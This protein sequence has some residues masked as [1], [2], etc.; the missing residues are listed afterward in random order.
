MMSNR[1]T[2]VFPGPQPDIMIVDH[3]RCRYTSDGP[4]TTA[5]VLAVLTKLEEMGIRWC[6][7]EL[8]NTVDGQPRYS[9]AQ[10]E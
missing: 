1:G 2:K 3:H 7:V 10:G 9:K 5:D 8:L 6:H 4:V